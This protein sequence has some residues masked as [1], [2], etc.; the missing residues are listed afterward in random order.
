MFSLPF[1]AETVPFL[2]VLQPSFGQTQRSGRSSSRRCDTA[3]P[4]PSDAL[5]LPFL[6]L[7]I[8][9]HRLSLIF[10]CLFTAFPLTFHCPSHRLSL[11][12]PLHFHC[13]ST[14]FSLSLHCLSLDLLLPFACR[15]RRTST[16]WRRATA[17]SSPSPSSSQPRC[18]HC[19]SRAFSLPFL[20]YSRPALPFIEALPPLIRCRR[21]R[22]SR[23][24]LPTAFPTAFLLPFLDLSLISHCI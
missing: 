19:L 6:G 16:G 12:L 15:W 22:A 4:W 14:A 1:A 7:P 20:V 10:R 17:A 3:F 5:Q 24:Y 9:F 21:G 18:G 13:L 23:A 11:D 2:V 8:P